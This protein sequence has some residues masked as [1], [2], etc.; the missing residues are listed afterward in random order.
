MEKNERGS[1]LVSSLPYSALSHAHTVMAVDGYA[2]EF[3]LP[4]FSTCTCRK[5]KPCTCWEGQSVLSSILFYFV[6]SLCGA[7]FLYR[8]G[9]FR[10]CILDLPCCEIQWREPRWLSGAMCHSHKLSWTLHSKS[11]VLALTKKNMNMLENGMAHVAFSLHLKNLTDTLCP[12]QLWLLQWYEWTNWPNKLLL[13]C[14][15][16]ENCYCAL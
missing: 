8:M 14:L 13:K 2:V 9:F 4:G 10:V 16:N 7:K 5:P 12:G 15:S 3:T 1:A 6:H 11:Q